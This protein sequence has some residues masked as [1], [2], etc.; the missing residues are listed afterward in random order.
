M[1]QIFIPIGIIALVAIVAGGALYFYQQQQAPTVEEPGNNNGVAVSNFA[2]CEAAGYPIMESFPRQCRTPQ[3]QNFT[4]DIGNEMEKT[5]LIR[6]NNP[7]PNQ[8][9]ASPLMIEG[10]ARGTWYF[11]AS[12]PIRL[13]DE[14]GN[15]LAVAIAQAQDEWMTEE[16]VPFKATLEFDTPE[17][18]VGTLVFQKDNPSGLPEH[19]DELLMPIRFGEARLSRAQDGCVITGCSGQVCADE[20]QIT[21]CEFRPEYACYNSAVCARQ[22]SGQCGWTQTAELTQCIENAKG[23]AQQLQEE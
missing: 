7:R 16:F 9:I 23:S 6:V 11:E 22:T 18:S 8:E 14:E 10:E 19:D 21:T 12:F 20:E 4:E 5:D 15:E 17:T 3:G 13:L 1:K 2:E